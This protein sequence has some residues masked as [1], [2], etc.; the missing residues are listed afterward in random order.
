MTKLFR[1]VIRKATIWMFVS[2]G[3]FLSP[4]LAMSAE[5]SV[6]P[7][8]ELREEYQDNIH[9]SSKT[10]DTVWGSAL[11]PS[12]QFA[13]TTPT[14]VS[15]ASARFR[16]NRYSRDDPR[17]TDVQYLTL[18]SRNRIPR[19]RWALNGLFKRDTTLTTLED[20]ASD[21]SDEADLADAED[22]DAGLVQVEVRR[23]RFDLDPSWSRNLTERMTLQLGYRFRDVYYS[24]AEGTSLYDYRRHS[25][26]VALMQQVTERYRHGITVRYSEYRAP[27]VNSEAD[28]S[29]IL[30]SMD[31]AFSETLRGI[32]ALG[33]QNTSSMR[34][35]IVDEATGYTLNM[36]L[37]KKINQS[38]NY[39]LELNHDVLPSGAGRVVQSDRFNI[40]FR[41]KIT[42]KLT[43]LLSGRFFRNKSLE[44]SA[45]YVDRRYYSIEP[46]LRRLLTR[47]WSVDGSYRYRY[48]KY[49]DASASAQSNA[50]FV[51]VRYA[52]PVIRV[53]R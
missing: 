2:G 46:G 42:S 51:G 39:R 24:S 10:H 28:T 49:D 35:A 13:R 50:V 32:V 22:I 15:R 5:W 21:T 6:V 1:Q 36:R 34:D 16:F 31:Y 30:A 26:E 48:Q 17:D 3:G 14:S 52:W 7:S 41:N 44:A 8:I 45:T 27:E 38:T 19:G 33:M 9:L 47:K 12:V 25:L 40:R 29:T 23:N 18:S 43:F 11:S 4:Q 20:A 53:S 37:T